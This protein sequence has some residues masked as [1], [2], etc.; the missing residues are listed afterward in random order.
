[1]VR[2]YKKKKSDPTPPETMKHAVHLVIHDGKPKRQVARE[3]GIPRSSLLR[4]IKATEE[5]GADAVSYRKSKATRKVF[6]DEQESLLKDYLLVAS[7]HHHGLT[8]QMARELAWEYA[9]ENK[10][11]YPS[12]WDENKAAGEDWV[13]GFMK[14][15]STL[16]CR[17]PEATSLS[18][19]TSFN[20]HNV[21]QFMD[22]L[23][24]L[25]SRYKFGPEDIYNMDETGLTTVHKPPK[26]IA[27]KKARQVG[28][29]TSAERGVLTTMVG[30]SSAAGT[31][32]PPMLIFPRV[33]FKPYMMTGAPAGSVGTANPS[34][35][36]CGEIFL[37]WLEH[38]I[39]Y[40]RP[41]SQKPALL[42]M[43]NHDSHLTIKAIELA[44]TNGVHMLTFPP[45]CSHKMQ[46]LDLSVYGPLK[47]YFASACN[48]W[49]LSHPGRTI[50]I[51]EIA[52]LLGQA[53][54]RAFTIDNITSGYVKP[55]IFPFDRDAFGDDEF[56][57]SFVTDREN[58]AAVADDGAV[59]LPTTP[60]HTTQQLVSAD[61]PSTSASTVTATVTPEQIRPY[62]KAPPR[63][64]T[65]RN[66]RKRSTAI[67]TDTPVKQRLEQQV[68]ERAAKKS[69]PTQLKTLRKVS[70]KH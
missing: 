38:F 19:G 61:E 21:N 25:M 43:D 57:S 52:S 29:V 10:R 37:Q 3:L 9:K 54:P 39:K 56:L 48:S 4:Y 63:A 30:C 17:K 22:N 59:L 64:S 62:P 44:K 28:Q 36:I 18:R 11:Q 6:T 47:R 1:M 16:S 33:N 14:R 2:T 26:I 32:I 24:S 67:L 20:R 23:E 34:G 31:A 5:R 40:S 46:P 13:Q 70:T 45:H 41:S 42:I 51:Y 49:Q 12:S 27:D 53:Y 50:T 7:K 15:H 55:G 58:P 66:N 60:T 8:Q 65:N 35:Y 68:S 69:K